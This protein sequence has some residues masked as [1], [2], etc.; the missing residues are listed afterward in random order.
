MV[1]AIRETKYQRYERQH[2]SY[3]MDCGKLVT[4]R[5]VRCHLCDNKNR[6]ETN[7]GE[8]NPNWKGGKTHNNGYIYLR[9]YREGKKHCYQAEHILVWEQANGKLP[10]G[11][12]VHHLNGIRKDNRLENLSA[13]PRERHNLKLAFQP[14]E[15]RI[16]QLE[17]ELRRLNELP[18]GDLE[19][20][21]WGNP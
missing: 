5:S 12:I 21:T 18:K 2:P 20:E 8:N 6:V 17:A 4:R 10:D 1:E 16:R 9:A 19:K 7:R 14:Y 15:E 11:W 13:M 3:C